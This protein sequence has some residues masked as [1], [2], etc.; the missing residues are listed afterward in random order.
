MVNRLVQSKRLT[1]DR[2]SS[3]EMTKRHQ[4]SSAFF[5]ATETQKTYER[6]CYSLMRESCF[7]SEWNLR[8]I[9]TFNMWN[10]ATSNFLSWNIVRELSERKQ[11]FGSSL[12]VKEPWDASHLGDRFSESVFN[13]KNSDL[14]P[15]TSSVRFSANVFNTARPRH[16]G[17]LQRLP[18]PTERTL[19]SYCPQSSPK[20]YFSSEDLLW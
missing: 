20:Q 5:P 2:I 12:S 15:W 6:F 7:I 1:K 14:D 9:R 13:T 10:N 4:S 16:E 3:N 17:H 8:N 11:E 19:S 18:F